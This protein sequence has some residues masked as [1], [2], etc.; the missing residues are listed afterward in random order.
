MRMRK[1]P[2]SCP[3]EPGVIR[4]FRN[5]ARLIA[6]PI[7][8][9]KVAIELHFGNGTNTHRSAWLVSGQSESQAIANATQMAS[10]E[11]QRELHGLQPQ[12]WK[13]DAWTQLQKPSGRVKQVWIP[14]LRAQ[15][16]AAGRRTLRRRR[17]RLQ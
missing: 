4:R 16:Q 12:V 14:N 2:Y 9:Y 10:A 6:V 1:R 15:R 5:R 3:L 17:A 8:F 11:L 7:E 13:V